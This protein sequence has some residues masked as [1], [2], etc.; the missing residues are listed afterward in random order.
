M[1][2]NHFRRLAG[3]SFLLIGYQSE[4]GYV[5]LGDG[6]GAGRRHVT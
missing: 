5:K 4:D 3:Q 1:R 6:L 2:E